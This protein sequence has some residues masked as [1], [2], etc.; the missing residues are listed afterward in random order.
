M[1][2][3]AGSRLALPVGGARW[4]RRLLP[5]VGAT[6]AL[7]TALAMSSNAVAAQSPTPSS[8]TG[9]TAG[10]ADPSVIPAAKSPAHQLPKN[11][12]VDESLPKSGPVTVML[13]LD[14]QP[15][16][17]TYS[18]AVDSGQSTA[19]ADTASR[20]QTQ[21]VEA[22][23][24]QVRS[25]LG[26]ATTKARA[27]FTTH[28]AYAGVAVTTDAS[29]LDALSKIPGVAAVH[30]MPVKKI[31]NSVTQPLIR[32]PQAWQYAGKTGKGVTIGIIDTGVDYTHADFG[33]PG[34]VA[35]YDAAK[36]ADAGP[37]TPTAKVVGGYDFVGDNYNADPNAAPPD[38]PYQPVPHPDPNPLD[39]NSHGTH[40][41]GTAAGY[42]EN[43]DGSTY[44]G[45]YNT[46]TPFSTMKIGPGVAP[47]ASI[48]ALKVF[49]C[50]GS[51]NV[52]SE[53]LDWALD[54]NGDGNISDHLDVVNMSLGSDYGSPLDPDSVAANNAMK[55]GV[56]VV[57]AAGN[58][59]DL[60][61]VGGSPG[62]AERVIGVA[63]SDDSTDWFD[64][65]RVDAPASIAGVKPVEYSISF[66]M[67]GKPD[68]TG[69]LYQLPDPTT[70][71]G[72][73]PYSA[74]DAAGV[75]G[76]VAWIEWT[77]NDATRR[78]GSATRANNATAAGA[79]GVVAHDDEDR[80]AAG[81]LGNSSIPM[82]LITKTAG[83]EILGAGVDNTTVTFSASLHLVTSLSNP[84]FN[85]EIVGFSSRGITADGIGKPDLA[86]P[87]NTIL[88]AGMGTGNGGL[89]DS[90][91]SMATP[92]AAGLAALVVQAHPNWT[93]EK[94]KAAMMN[95]AT[96]DVF[97]GPGQT[98]TVEAPERVGAGR[99]VSDAAVEQQ[100]LAYNNTDPGSVGVSFGVLNVSNHTSVSKRVTVENT[101]NQPATYKLSYV[102]STAVPGVTVSL[103]Q[104]YAKVPAHSR[105]SFTVRLDANASQ[106]THTADPAI[107]TTNDLGGGLVL[108]RQFISE[109][110]GRVILTPQGA[111]AG[112]A[113]R[114]PVYS[115]PRPV[116]Q[117]SAHQVGGVQFHKDG[118][119]TGQLKLTGQGV[120][121]GSGAATEQSLVSGYELQGTSPKM[122]DCTAKIVS[123]CIPFPDERAADLKQVGVSSD[124]TAAYFA[125]N[126]W[127][128]WYT[129]ASY[130]EFDILIDTNNDGSPDFVLFNSRFSGTDIFV[131]E[132]YNLAT[133]SVDDI[134]LL[135]IADG[136]FDTDVYHTDTMVMPVAISALGMTG[137][138]R[139]QY[140]V[141]S[142]TIYGTMDS[143]DTWMS[144]DPM[145]PGLQL[146]Q[147]GVNDVLYPDM[148]GQV[149][150][151]VADP[152]SLIRDRS[153]TLMLVHDMNRTGSRV[154]DMSLLKAVHH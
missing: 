147:G 136:S 70:P 120:S 100:V 79:I 20:A 114:V 59:G 93:T 101:S 105:T 84:A 26:D 146:T 88:S 139:F 86:A 45:A 94:I 152:K 118:T 145:H 21:K 127:G 38:Q 76:K 117:M 41:A 80:F 11:S 144:F 43:A 148:P 75:K 29:R 107:D 63:A 25:H 95:T 122:P 142:Q 73:Q 28:A 48:Y 106:M 119:I 64:G 138:T 22:L 49:G 109:A 4:R 151:V 121:S 37:W 108:P 54:P 7:T 35:A 13:Q 17:A 66:D 39:C 40:V 68:V 5:T 128:E 113:L 30:A 27:L 58:G 46:S 50:S 143:I 55:A 2:R 131:T 10:S 16:A 124:G 123:G 126:T 135:N 116:S 85:D 57:V 34:T 62:N 1:S 33:G 134:E 141:Q 133:N 137:S 3:F 81:L 18:D 78:C 103:S 36:A 56:V 60:Y 115:A 129:P 112:S 31:D 110:S 154:E 130:V 71:D 83:D 14:A 23:A 19:A 96:Q 44:T 69:Q 104:T 8:S 150:T 61:G 125:V 47:Q 90:G 149:L 65:L 52:V 87:G 89:N 132:L 77:D 9:S 91:T 98:G 42:G 15:A 82:V 111:T 67:A 72:C 92:H 140:Q 6:A 12:R 97:A 153:D 53:A 51:T 74:A 99:I 102:P 24:S 32:A